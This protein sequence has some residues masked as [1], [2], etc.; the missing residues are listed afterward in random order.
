M[1]TNCDRQ[2]PAVGQ[3]PDKVFLHVAQALEAHTLNGQTA[4]RVCEAA[5]SLIKLTNTDPM[6]LLQQFPP[7]AQ[8]V[9]MGF[10]N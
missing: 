10:F 5:K 6:P 4:V 2:H 1:L 9:V 3:Q 7:D 8:Q